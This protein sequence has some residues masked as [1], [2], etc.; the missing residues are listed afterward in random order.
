M[1]PAPDN[2]SLHEEWVGEPM[3]IGTPVTT[4]RMAAPVQGTAPAAPQAPE[5]AATATFARQEKKSYVSP[6]LAHPGEWVGE[7]HAMTKPARQEEPAAPQQ[8][9]EAQAAEAQPAEA[10]PDD[11]RNRPVKEMPRTATGRMILKLL[12]SAGDRPQDADKTLAP[13]GKPD[14]LADL[15]DMPEQDSVSAP[16]PAAAPETGLTRQNRAVRPALKPSGK[17]NS[18]MNFIAGAAEALRHTDHNDAP[19]ACPQG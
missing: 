12:G 3:P 14:L 4:A 7:P 19:P 11:R 17:G 15:A 5:Y 13:S 9:A 18:I 1:K 16:V 8:S 6:S 10:Q 2:Y